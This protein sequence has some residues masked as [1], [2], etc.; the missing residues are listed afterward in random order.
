MQR[1]L[2][3]PLETTYLETWRSRFSVLND[4]LEVTTEGAEHSLEDGTNA[5]IGVGKTTIT[6][7]NRAYWHAWMKESSQHRTPLGCGTQR[8]RQAVPLVGAKPRRSGG[9]SW[10][11]APGGC[12]T[13]WEMD[14]MREKGWHIF[15]PIAFCFG[16]TSCCTSPARCNT[17]RTISSQTHQKLQLPERPPG[18]QLVKAGIFP[19]ATIS[20]HRQC[21]REA[22][23]N[24]AGQ[25]GKTQQRTMLKGMY[26][27]YKL[28]S[29]SA[30]VQRDS[31]S[32]PATLESNRSSNIHGEDTS[33]NRAGPGVTKYVRAESIVNKDRQHSQHSQP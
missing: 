31:P 10:E 22:T 33:T 1:D 25:G 6:C 8:Y 5:C 3:G 32:S 7:K 11:A 18:Q 2:Q 14:C 17:W 12:A 27:N 20:E 16:A 30:C 24:W 21:H 9:K 13:C 15:L 28:P 29:P 4:G 23:K 26:Y 19:G